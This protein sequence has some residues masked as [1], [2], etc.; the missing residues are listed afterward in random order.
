A[1]QSLVPIRGQWPY[2]DLFAIMQTATDGNEGA[3]ARALAARLG[4]YHDDPNN[5]FG[6]KDVPYA[7]L[8]LEGVDTLQQPL[9]DF[10]VACDEART[11]DRLRR[12]AEAAIRR[13]RPIRAGDPSLVDVRVLCE[14]LAD[15]RGV[16]GTAAAS[17]VS[18]LDR[19]VIK[20][21][22]SQ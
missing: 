12:A 13:A 4:T 5:R 1:S 22:R 9:A 20:W 18:A 21:N 7:L 3:V 10:V 14:T 11:R 15:S 16:L 8:D 2:V 6:L 19:S 17:V